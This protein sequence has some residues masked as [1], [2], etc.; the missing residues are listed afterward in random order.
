MTLRMTVDV[1]KAAA[2]TQFS[3]VMTCFRSRKKN[4]AE[5]TFW[6]SV[7]VMRSDNRQSTRSGKVIRQV[8]NYFSR[9]DECS[10]TVTPQKAGDAEYGEAFQNSDV[11]YG[12]HFF[13]HYILLLWLMGVGAKNDD[14]NATSYASCICHAGH[15]V[16]VI[17]N[18]LVVRS[19]L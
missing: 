5:I 13:S 8:I 3:S 2:A 17:I 1:Q 6:L 15:A 4:V 9:D 18:S 10:I 12:M 14:D 7:T 16:I 11:L 19:M